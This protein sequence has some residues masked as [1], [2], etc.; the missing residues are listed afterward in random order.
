MRPSRGLALSRAELAY[1]VAVTWCPERRH[2]AL[3]PTAL[4]VRVVMVWDAFDGA[5]CEKFHGVEQA[6][7]V[8]QW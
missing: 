2:W 3:I 6:E 8:Y 1:V 7:Q 4:M 5:G